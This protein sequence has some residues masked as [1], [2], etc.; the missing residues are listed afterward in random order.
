[1][2]AVQ[3]WAVHCHGADTNLSAQCCIV[4]GMVFPTGSV[5]QRQGVIPRRVRIVAQSCGV[6]A[7]NARTCEQEGERCARGG[8]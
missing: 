1:V 6:R 3:K 7:L 5:E 2:L 4:A 8:P